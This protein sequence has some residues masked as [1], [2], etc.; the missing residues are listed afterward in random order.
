MISSFN[1]LKTF[2]Y[3][4]LFNFD[5]YITN[6]SYRNKELLEASTHFIQTI[7]EDT[8]TLTIEHPKPK[9]TG[10]YKCVVINTAG[11]DICTAKLTVTGKKSDLI[12]DLGF[13]VVKN[14]LV[15]NQFRSIPLII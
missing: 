2:T 7:E 9:D 5:M 11:E 15:M 12:C 1:D 10:E 4:L 14:Y 8:A 6:F 13:T 3:I